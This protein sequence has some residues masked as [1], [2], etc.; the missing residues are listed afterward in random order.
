MNNPNV[1]YLRLLFLPGTPGGSR[2]VMWRDGG[3]GND[4]CDVV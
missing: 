4:R 2:G 1:K 3:L